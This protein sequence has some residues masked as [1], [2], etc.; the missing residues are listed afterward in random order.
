VHKSI[1]NVCPRTEYP[2][3]A[4]NEDVGEDDPK[5]EEVG[6]DERAKKEEVHAVGERTY[7]YCEYS[8]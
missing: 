1:P 4:K 7:R 6:E 8:A 5:S 2:L 3:P